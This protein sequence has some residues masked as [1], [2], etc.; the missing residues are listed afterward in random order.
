MNPHK[1]LKELGFTKTIFHKPGYNSGSY[2]T[3]MMPDDVEVSF[4]FIDGKRVKV[5]KKKVHPKSDSFWTLKYSES[6]ILW[7]LVKNHH[8]DKI[9]LENKNKVSNGAYW[10]RNKKDERL[11]LVF[12]YNSRETSPLQG[13]TQIMSLLPKEI[14]RDFLL[15][16]LFGS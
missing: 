16:Q 6:Y 11:Q 8:I 14:K 1:K 15:D 7:C 10:N 4:N 3:C 2:E 9:W 5:E 13:K 12:D